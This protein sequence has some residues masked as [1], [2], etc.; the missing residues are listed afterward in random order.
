MSSMSMTGTLI[1]NTAPHQKCAR[2]RPPNTGPM[3]A[4]A[5]KL[6]TQMPMANAR[7]CGSRNMLRMSESVDGASVA[8]GE[9]LQCARDDQH[10]GAGRVGGEDRGDAERRG[11]DEQH[12]AAPDPVAERA[13]GDQRAG[14]HEAVDVDD[15]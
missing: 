14:D 10:L 15:P 6:A 2:I 4:P 12:L 5:E 9:T 7:S 8:A 11:A 3:T 1:R 13:H